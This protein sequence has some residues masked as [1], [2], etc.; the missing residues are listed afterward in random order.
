VEGQL[1]MA[2]K[3]NC[4]WKIFNLGRLP[5]RIRPPKK[6]LCFSYHFFE[7][8]FEPSIIIFR[9]PSRPHFLSSAPSSPWPSKVVR[10]LTLPLFWVR[11]QALTSFECAF[12]PSLFLSTFRVLTFFRGRLRAL[13]SFSSAPLSS[14]FLFERALEPSLP[15]ECAFEPSPPSSAPSSPLLPFKCSFELSSQG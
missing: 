5:M 8:A 14:R 13:A 4:F 2:K 1:E 15:F 6:S 3:W 7:C 11:L 10:F 9:A 12:E